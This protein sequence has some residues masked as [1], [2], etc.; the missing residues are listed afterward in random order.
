MPGLIVRKRKIVNYLENEDI[1]PIKRKKQQDSSNA[2]SIIPIEIIHNIIGK[3]NTKDQ[4]NL[5]KVNRYFLTI[6]DSN[7]N[8]L[9]NLTLY[10]D[11]RGRKSLIEMLKFIG[12]W[13]R[14]AK[15]KINFAYKLTELDLDLLEAHENQNDGKLISICFTQLHNH[16]LQILEYFSSICGSLEIQQFHRKSKEPEEFSDKQIEMKNLHTL[17]VKFAFNTKKSNDELNKQDCTRFFNT[18]VIDPI[19]FK[20]FTLNDFTGSFNSVL[21]FLNS[22]QM[23]TFVLDCDFSAVPDQNLIHENLKFSSRMIDIKRSYRIIKTLFSRF[24]NLELAEIILLN[25]SEVL[26]I[27][28][29]LKGLKIFNTTV[30]YSRLDIVK[31]PKS[32]QEITFK[33]VIRDRHEF[34]LFLANKFVIENNG[35]NL[36]RIEFHFDINCKTWRTEYYA[37]KCHYLLKQFKN[38]KEIFLFLTCSHR[39]IDYLLRIQSTSDSIKLEDILDTFKSIPECIPKPKIIFKHTL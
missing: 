23:D 19:K 35:E 32:I 4:L 1:S 30:H 6:V 29:N 18:L 17:I 14:V 25:T 31:F 26:T 28:S 15:L 2:F 33:H 24:I 10:C 7:N 34:D 12:K 5:R 8:F 13:K 3:L 20:N 36:A 9:N 27:N 21:N 38:L 11:I 37:Q 22:T 39:S 16:S